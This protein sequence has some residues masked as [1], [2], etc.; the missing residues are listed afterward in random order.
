MRRFSAVVLVLLLAGCGTLAPRLQPPSLQVVGVQLVKADLTRQDL[1]VRLQVHNPN[2]ISLPVTRIDYQLD[3]AGQPAAEGRSERAFTV[4]AHGSAEF[5][6]TA[7]VNGLG[8]VTRLL[9]GGV[10]DGKLDYE[11][12]GAVRLDSALRRQLP[13]RQRGELNLR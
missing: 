7:T 3:V 4:P 6:V 2:A 10:R 12:R 5:D 8:V 1:R 13:F 11:L 9:S